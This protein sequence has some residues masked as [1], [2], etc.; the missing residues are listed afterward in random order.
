[1]PD[2]TDRGALLGWINAR[3]RNRDDSEHNQAIVR[4]ALVAMIGAYYLALNLG[5][6]IS[7]PVSQR[8]G[9]IG[10]AYLLLSALYF[11]LILVNPTRSPPRR[12]VA[13]ASDMAALTL[14]ISVLGI[15][16]TVLHPVYLWIT[17]GN[18]FRYGVF[19]L[20]ASAVTGLIG[21]ATIVATTD[22]PSAG[23]RIEQY[24][25]LLGLVIVPAYAASL[26]RSLRQAKAE[27][28]AAS[29]A[30]SRFLANMSHELRTPL[31]SII[32][33]SD[34]L[35]KTR[36]DNEQREM[37][38]TVQTS[39]HALLGLINEILDLSKVEAGRMPVEH[40]SFDLHRELAQV[41][42]ILR[43]QTED[44]GLSLTVVIDATLPHRLSGDIQHLRQ[45]LLNLGSNAG[46]FTDRGGVQ[47]TVTALERS[48]QALRLRFAVSDT[49]IGMTEDTKQEVF[50]SFT[51]GKNTTARQRGGTGLG[52]TISQHLA[53]LLG[54]RITVRTQEDRGSTFVLELPLTTADDEAQEPTGRAAEPA[55]AHGLTVIT[56][57]DQL[58]QAIGEAVVETPW[59]LTEERTMD[60]FGFRL[61]AGDQGYCM[62]CLDARSRVA[63]VAHDLGRLRERAGTA[64]V[65]AVVIIDTRDDPLELDTVLP[66][67]VVAT[68]AEPIEGEHLLKAL[69]VLQVFDPASDRAEPGHA[70]VGSTPVQRRSLRILAAEDNAVNRRVTAK[71]LEGAGHHVE[72]VETADAA[73]DRVEQTL[74]DA[75]LMDVNLPGTTGIEAVKLY[76]FAHTD[77]GGPP[78]I[79]LTADVTEETRTACL[80]AG[81]AGFIGKPI[82]ATRLLDTLDAVVAGHPAEGPPSARA[83]ASG[84]VTPI[85]SHPT[86]ASEAGPALDYDALA[87]LADLDDDPAFLCD[88]LADFRRDAEGLLERLVAALERGDI[89]TARDAAHALRG[90]SANTGARRL[91]RAATTL[92]ES[93]PGRLR[94]DATLSRAREL[95]NE[96]TRFLDAAHAFL[97]ERI[98]TRL[99]R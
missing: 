32:G 35:R 81:M 20:A 72:M 99:L 43:A 78:F 11:G 71:I 19:Y 55:H 98:G 75:V 77:G 38:G 41:A 46:K 52:L 17:L 26:I 25:L 60:E 49:G 21:F 12:L 64:R 87:G 62:V 22:Y 67:D 53:E 18:G 83:V 28:E 57:D 74:F 5:G 40:V 9:W 58:R 37:A 8:L 30:K 61:A 59:S 93:P 94:S 3:L 45:I 47:L 44:R 96:L 10:V 70:D 66:A 86:Y 80:D 42:A 97:S 92:L 51:Q 4:L 39:G 79:A 95:H 63:A 69:R 1:M 84:K 76:R 23:W 7:A 24:G 82:D 65:G 33:M 48:R 68:V 6:A 54:G 73:L 90:T 85:D 27:A 89:G 91:R 13:M 56:T 34:L 14:T 15:W 50:A 36:L 31:N 16:G 88:V 29:E 2:G